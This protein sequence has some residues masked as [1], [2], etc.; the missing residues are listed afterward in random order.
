[1]VSKRQKL[2]RK[3]FK[4]ANPELHPKP[5]P[6]PTKDPTQKK[7]KAKF[8]RKKS[9]TKGGKTI[10]KSRKS[11]FRKHPL[12]VPGSKPGEACFICKAKD[13]IAKQC[14]Q[15]AQWEKNKICLLCRHRGHTLK[16]CPSKQHEASDKKLCY[17]CGEIG[18]SLSNCPHPLQDGGTKYADCFI[19]KEHG[20]LSKNCPRNKHGIYPKGGCC[21]I[22]GGLTHLA[23]DCPNKGHQVSSA[24]VTAM[25]ASKREAAEREKPRRQLMR[26]VSGDDLE[27]DFMIKVNDTGPIKPR[28]R[29]TD[30]TAQPIDGYHPKVKNPGPK[31]V[32]FS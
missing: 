7:K 4:E 31:V 12:R 23:K 20:H 25:D 21:K 16:N 15:K 14:P 27:D 3:R 9:E 28:K 1:M 17:N 24:V 11:T 10:D 5:E 18:H 6:T 26:L 8:K 13:H 22:C 29:K 19:C 32:I 30:S 2:A